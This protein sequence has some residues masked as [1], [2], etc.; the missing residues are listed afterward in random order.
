MNTKLC[1]ICQI[2]YP[3]LA[4]PM[5]SVT[6][7]PFVIAVS[8]SGGLGCLATA[9]IKD[10]TLFNDQVSRIRDQTNASFAVNVAWAVPGSKK[11]LEWCL[12]SNI[13]I[14]ISSAGMPTEGMEKLKK[15]GVKILQMV[16]N[17]D[18]AKKAENM[19]VD[20][21]IAKGWEAGGMNSTNAVSTFA[22]VPQV[23]D[24]VS[25]PV[26][27]AGGI[28]DGRGLAA[29]LALGAGGILM[30]TR[31]LATQECPIHNSFKELL[32]STSDISTHS[33]HSSNFTIRFLQNKYA[34]SL[35]PDDEI[36][37]KLTPLNEPCEKDD[38]LISIG[39]I[40]GLVNDIIPVTE[41]VQKM[42]RHYKSVTASLPRLEEL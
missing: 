24:A 5:H 31:F 8:K 20:A 36:W 14:V 18:Q 37:S 32:M 33:Y 23:V 7:A 30:G 4:G 15:S 12:E 27:A 9:G 38:L 22:L 13:S 10:R 2:P 41:F 16:A 39:Q 19:G 29:A 11:V 28:A 21:L 17:V 3:I 1:Q 25:I 34:E 40:S 42:I 26:V 6:M 35:K